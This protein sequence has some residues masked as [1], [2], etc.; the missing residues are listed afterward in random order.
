MA[1]SCLLGYFIIFQANHQQKNCK[2]N[3]GFCIIKKL[4]HSPCPA[5]GTTRAVLLLMQGK[6]K[7]AILLNPLALIIGSF[8]L[9]MPLWIFYD[10]AFK[11]KTLEKKYYQAE[12]FLKQK[13]VIIISITLVVL[14]WIW[15][16]K[17]NV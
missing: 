16:I 9:L 15:N 4:T 13:P 17:K 6:I 11:K 5:C 10:I 8:L 7:E 12:I 2:N 14:N 1:A 3:V